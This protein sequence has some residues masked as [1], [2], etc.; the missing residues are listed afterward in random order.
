MAEDASSLSFQRKTLYILF[1]M[2]PP[3]MILTVLVFSF[4]AKAS[5]HRLSAQVEGEPFPIARALVKRIWMAEQFCTARQERALLY[6]LDRYVVPMARA[7]ARAANP[8]PGDP[9]ADYFALKFLEHFATTDQETR[10]EVSRRFRGIAE[11]AS[12]GGRVLIYCDDSAFEGIPEED[13]PCD[14][15]SHPGQ[16]DFTFATSNF[17]GN[18]IVLVLAFVSRTCIV[19]RRALTIPVVR[20]VLEISRIHS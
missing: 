1:A 16:G 11:E 5:H 2:W 14:S 10:H 3:I 6:V 12:R 13:M 17:A 7:A 4:Y 8:G 15:E 18:Y 19:S 20:T 9:D